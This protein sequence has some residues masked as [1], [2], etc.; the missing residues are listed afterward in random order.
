MFQSFKTSSSPQ[1]VAGRLSALR[2]EMHEMQIAW[3]LV[4]HGDEY[5]NEYPP[6]RAQR[7]S[8]LTGFTG[9]AGFA[10]VGLEKAYV[11]SDGRYTIQ[12][13]RQTDT[14]VFT[15]CNSVETPPVEFAAGVIQPGERI[16]FDPWLLSINQERSW[17]R[18]TEKAGAELVDLPNLIDRVW[19]DQPAAPNGRAFLHPDR[20]A[21]EPASAKLA[22]IRSQLADDGATHLVLTDPASIAWAFNLRGTDTVHNPLMLGF[23]LIAADPHERPVLFASPS[24]FDE[25][26]L[27]TLKTLTGLAAPRE[28]E[29]RLKSLG[30]SARLHADPGLVASRL[31]VIAVD[32]GITLVEKRDPVVLMRAIKNE[33]ELTGMRAAHLRDGV[34]MSRFLAWL[35]GNSPAGQLTEIEA[36]GKLEELRAQTAR[37]MDSELREIAFDT[38]SGAGANGAIV[39]YRVSEQTNATIAPGSLYL[40][41]SGGQ[42]PDGTTDITRTIAIGTP[43]ERA[44]RDFTLVLKG[45]IAI[46]TAR[47]PEGTRGV[48]LDPLARI[49]L[50]K[51][52]SDYAHGTGHGIGAYMNVHEGPQSISRRGMEPLRAGMVVSNEPGCY[53]EGEYGIRI[54]NL[55][56]V[57]AASAVGLGG[58]PMLGFETITLCPLDKRLIDTDL[59]ERH[60][61][62]WLNAYHARVREAL[63]PHLANADLAWLERVTAPLELMPATGV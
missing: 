32:A 9:S 52:G 29:S 18:M 50:W 28:L 54:E 31:A 51:D 25:A 12:L 4:P 19:E 22:R 36:A 44:R 10:L 5:Q 35:D 42:Y 8:W 1:Q 15:P 40:V 57:E 55:L 41:D 39:H 30:S 58:S 49:A 33:T 60:E 2:R 46:A 43:P 17:R 6:E 14:Q 38:I 23:A 56:I 27:E 63:S 48:D 37:E 13:E 26:D 16:G 53:R 45:H 62:D 47:F 34:A 7:L 61:L 59:L 24:R 21:G 20:Y 11:F 3:Y